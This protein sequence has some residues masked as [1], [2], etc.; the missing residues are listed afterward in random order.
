MIQLVGVLQLAKARGVR[1]GNIDSNVTRIA[2]SFMQA[3]KVI[4]YRFFHRRSEI[5]ADVNPQ[6]AF[7]IRRF[8]VCDKPVDTIIVETH[9]IDNR[10]CLRDAKQP[11]FGISRLRTGCDCTDFYKAETERRQRVDV[12]AVL[13]Q[14][15]GEPHRIGETQPHDS[16]RLTSYWMRFGQSKP[17]N[18]LHCS[19]RNAM[20]CFR[21]EAEYQRAEKRVKHALILTSGLR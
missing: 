15:G 17:A 20:G 3:C 5:F 2:I 21:F 19:K 7:V 9:A 8:D 18:R 11:W 1:R 13:G 6:Y 12:F 4:V 14:S 16:S 10:I